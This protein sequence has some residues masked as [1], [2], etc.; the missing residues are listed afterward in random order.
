MSLSYL[1]E[2]NP[3]FPDSALA[4]DDPNGLLAVGGNLEPSTLIAAYQRGIFPWFTEDQMILWWSPCPRTILAPKELHLGRSTRKSLKKNRL[5][6]TVDQCFND[7][8]L[9]CAHIDRPEQDGTWINHQMLEAYN[10]L[11]KQGIAHSIEVWDE[12]NLVGGLYGINL[13]RAFFGESMFSK[14][15]GASKVAFTTLASQLK[16]WDF[17]LIDCQVYTEYLASFGAIE[18]DRNEFESRLS[19][20]VNHPYF[21]W[22][23]NWNMPELGIGGLI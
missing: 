20:A 3:C 7:V 11:H 21:D 19:K 15:S 18:V 12:H 22:K 4:L 14:T 1:D 6:V 9:N 5:R 2:I 17:E 8:M 23:E 13:G 10:D 16:Q